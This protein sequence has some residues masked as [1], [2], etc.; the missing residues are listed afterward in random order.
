MILQLWDSWPQA[1]ASLFPVALHWN[2][3]ARAA[4]GHSLSIRSC[5][6]PQKFV[7]GWFELVKDCS[8]CVSCICF[9]GSLDGARMKNRFCFVSPGGNAWNRRG[10]TRR[11]C[12]FC[13]AWGVAACREREN[14]TA[15]RIRHEFHW[16][17]SKP[18]TSV[19][20][21][22]ILTCVLSFSFS[23]PHHASLASCCSLPLSPF[24][25]RSFYSP[26]SQQGYCINIL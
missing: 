8:G 16:S 13:R 7:Q 23:M 11:G 5:S 26:V 19:S 17:I 24:Q 6:G 18:R 2:S 3:L 12:G 14:S 10:K 4:Q 25:F 21:K 1:S 15:G 20:Q 9:V 22:Q